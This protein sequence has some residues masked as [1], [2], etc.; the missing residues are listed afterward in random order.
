MVLAARTALVTE[1]AGGLALLPAFP[2]GWYGAGVELHDAPTVH[3]RLS[4]AVRWHGRRPAV[5]WELEP[6]DGPVRISVPGLDADWSTTELRGDALL[7]EVAPPEG[8]D[9]VREVAEHPD[10]DPVMRRPSETPVDL[11]SSLPE[12]G[13]F[14]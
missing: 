4:Y 11:P 3:G 13:S 1:S 8:L 5:L 6:H 7:N 9:L 14:S 2:P 10:I 12:G